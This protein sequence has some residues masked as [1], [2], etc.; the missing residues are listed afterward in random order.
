MPYKIISYEFNISDIYD[1]YLLNDINVEAWE[2]LTK[3]N[4]RFHRYLYLNLFKN[5][6]STLISISNKPLLHVME[7]YKL[8]GIL[9]FDNKTL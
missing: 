1:V 3:N 2:K 7:S 9:C 6:K 5:C 4:V 8:Y